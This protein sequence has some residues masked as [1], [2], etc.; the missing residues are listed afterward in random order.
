[1][2]YSSLKYFITSTIVY[3]HVLIVHFLTY[4]YVFIV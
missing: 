1:M 4:K 2:K 3:F